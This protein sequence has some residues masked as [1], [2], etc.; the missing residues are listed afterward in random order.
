MRAHKAEFASTPIAHLANERLN[1]RIVTGAQAL[2]YFFKRMNRNLIA[3][4]HGERN[5]RYSEQ[6]GPSKF[7]KNTSQNKYI[8]PGPSKRFRGE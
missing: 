6:T 7:P 2:K 5:E 1:R 8:Q 3:K 4:R